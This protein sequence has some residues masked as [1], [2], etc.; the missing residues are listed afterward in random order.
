MEP[1]QPLHFC[2]SNPCI[3]QWTE[4]LPAILR[5]GSSVPQSQQSLT[6]PPTLDV[7][8]LVNNTVSSAPIITPIATMNYL[9]YADDVVLIGPKEEM[10]DLLT[11]CEQHSYKLGYKWNP[12]KCVIV[13]RPHS[14]PTKYQ[15][16]KSTIPTDTAFTYLGIPIYYKR[17]LD[18]KQLIERNTISAEKGFRLLSSIGI[19]PTGISKLLSVRIY[20]QFIRPK[21]EYG[22]AIIT[23]NKKQQHALELV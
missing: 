8:S 11:K 15:L 14:V 13:E 3:T 20:T 12:T 4:N 5:K 2:T 21:L 18:G 10:Q 1:F 23:P 22:L 19:S 9:L 7:V 6:V 17:Q 16:Y